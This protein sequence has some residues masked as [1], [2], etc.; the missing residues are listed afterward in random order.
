MAL[1]KI[2]ASQKL[3]LCWECYVIIPKEIKVLEEIMRSDKR[4]NSCK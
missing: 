3:F 4:L 1:T 2:I